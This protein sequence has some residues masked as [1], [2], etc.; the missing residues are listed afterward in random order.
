MIMTGRPVGAEEALSM[1]LANRVVP[2]GTARQEA[3]KMA[4]QIA[5]FPNLCMLNDR[6]SAYEGLHMSFEAAMRNEF[7]LGVRT[8]ESGETVDGATR[9]ARGSGRHGSFD[10][11]K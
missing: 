6:R 1:G 3:E 10:E 7:R 11:F 5:R 2:R 8:L 4:A 9:F